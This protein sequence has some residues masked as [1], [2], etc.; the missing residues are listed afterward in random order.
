VQAGL[1]EDHRP[2]TRTDCPPDWYRILED[3]NGVHVI[4]ICLLSIRHWLSL[5]PGKQRWGLFCVSDR[6]RLAAW[7]MAVLHGY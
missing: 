3:R 6:L 2:G 4:L 7:C 1:V 5:L